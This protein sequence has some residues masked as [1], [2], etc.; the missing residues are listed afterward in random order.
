M[1]ENTEYFRRLHD[2]AKQIVDADSADADA[3]AALRTATLNLAARYSDPEHALEV[4]CL[5]DSEL[6]KDLRK[7]AAIITKDDDGDDD[8][9]A[10]GDRSDENTSL[11][12]HPIVRLAQLLVASGHK[13]DIASALDHL[14]N[15]SHGA[16]LLHRVR[17]QKGVDPMQDTIHAIMKSAGIAATCAQIVAKGRTT[18]SQEDI[19]SA[20]G[21]VAVE[22]W[23]ELSEAQAF[24][25]IYTSATDE[26]R[27]LQKAIEIAKLS[28]F[29]I[30]PTMVGGVDATHEANDS[31]Q[32]EAARQLGEMAEK[33]RAA[34]ATPLSADQAFARVFENPKNAALAAKMHRRPQPTTSFAFQK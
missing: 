32:S 13:A 23:P 3:A 20:V 16:A 26:A 2:V 29:D 24:S 8:G 33:L 15:T 17:T 1:N 18:I 27:V 12:D 11:A 21:K 7:A 28:A 4:L 19:C 10:A 6:S 22:R 25:K 30:Q 14:L 5:G 34:S 9:N 31:E